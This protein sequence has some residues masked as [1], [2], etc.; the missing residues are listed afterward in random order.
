MLSAAHD[1]LKEQTA[2]N[3]SHVSNITNITTVSLVFKHLSSILIKF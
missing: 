1:I 3:S 2:P